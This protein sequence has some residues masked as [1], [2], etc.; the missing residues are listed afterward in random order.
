MKCKMNTN[1][2]T[3]VYR[4]MFRGVASYACLVLLLALTLL[5]GGTAPAYALPSVPLQPHE[6]LSQ[7]NEE[8]QPT[9]M[10]QSTEALQ[11]KEVLQ[12]VEQKLRA[13][14]GVEVKFLMQDA[15]GNGQQGTLFLQGNSFKL[16]VAGMVTWFDGT[17]QWTLMEDSEEV[18][19][20]R[21]APEEMQGIHPYAWLSLY[22]KGYKLS[23][24]SQGGKA[25][26]NY[27][28]LMKANDPRQ[29][30]IS[31]M[32]LYID[33]ESFALRKVVLTPNGGA[34]M[35]ISV[36]QYKEQPARPSTFF[37]FDPKAYPGVEVVDLR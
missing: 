1:Y 18:T 6:E 34:G 28:I 16:V 5:P 35:T 21:P 20:A 27:V 37:T 29:E 24:Q 31:T 11:P 7:P 17:T 4:L 12:R 32:L 30:A 19:I 22:K 23:F 8:L 26:A 10:L 9:E 36:E 25:S 3:K 13:S 33:K 15:G 2:M 14:R